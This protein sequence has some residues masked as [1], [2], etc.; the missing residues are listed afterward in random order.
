MSMTF[1][2]LSLTRY[3]MQTTFFKKKEDSLVKIG[4]A[5]LLP[6]KTTFDFPRP[7]CLF[8]KLV[9]LGRYVEIYIPL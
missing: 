8:Y 3:L 9:H 2:L 6:D 7:R 4:P 5:K 1:S